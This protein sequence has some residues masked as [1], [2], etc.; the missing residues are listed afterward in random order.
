MRLI[1]IAIVCTA[2]CVPQIA[3]TEENRGSAGY[4]L[5]LCKSWL[6]VASFDVGAVKSELATGNAK[7]GGIVEHL[8]VAGMCAGT[9]IGIFEALRAFQLICPP[10]GISNQQL[11]RMAVNHIER[12]PETM[13]EDFIVPVG[14]RLM[15]TWPCHK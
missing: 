1:P 7:P 15:A 8:T 6:Q 4:M 11:V 14:A 10:D 5:P 9:V 13:H 3:K 12:R 2:V